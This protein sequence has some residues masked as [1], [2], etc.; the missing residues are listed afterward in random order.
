MIGSRALFASGG[1]AVA[2]LA[3]LLF[4][5][6]SSMYYRATAGEGCTNCH[7]MRPNWETWKQS[8][9]RSVSCLACHANDELANARRAERHVRGN[10]PEQIRVRGLDVVRLMQRCKTCHRQEFADWQAGPHGSAFAKVF[11]DSKHNSQRLLMDDCL[12]CHGSYYEGGIRSLV[13]PVDTKGPWTFADA[14]WADAPVAPCY[15]C[16]QIHRRGEP[17]K[18][19]R[20]PRPHPAAAQEIQRPSLAHFD[21]RELAHVALADLP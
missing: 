15:A 12:R 1:L 5:P 16:H 21:R 11:L 2:M 14:R 13:R 7:E 18:A 17:L 19:D 20:A 3:A 4:V 9:H 8:T 10:V 6:A